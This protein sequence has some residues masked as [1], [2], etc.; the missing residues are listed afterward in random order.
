MLDGTLPSS[1]AAAVALLRRGGVVGLP[2]ETVYGL[3]AD[4][5]NEGALRKIF[6]IKGRPADHPLIVHIASARDLGI[7]ASQ[8]PDIAHVLAENFWPGPLTM[9]VRRAERTSLVATGGRETVAIRVPA[10]D[11]AL[12]LLRE[13]GGALAAPSA[14]RFGKVS[15]TTP[16]HVLDDLGADVDLILDGGECSI[17]VESTIVD[18]TGTAPMVLRPGGVSVER[19]ESILKIKIE[20]EHGN[21]RAPGMLDSHYAPRCEIE[22]VESPLAA[23]NR[24][25]KLVAASRSV[26]VLD[27]C[28]DLDAYARHLYDFLRRADRDG[29]EVVVAVMPPAIGLGHAIRD[30]LFKASTR[31]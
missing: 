11:V 26:L 31:N 25:V 1:I 4:A 9:L 2:T 10:H 3:A 15:P 20:S 21:S 6:A 17:G 14:N 28:S 5:E 18:L 12:E 16:Q 8:V 24:V 7:W 13:F 22:L 30:R 19:L 29:C 27:F 23:R